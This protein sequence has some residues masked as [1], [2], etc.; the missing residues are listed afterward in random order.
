MDR[1]ER[2]ILRFNVKDNKVTAMN[3]K[4]SESIPL[5]ISLQSGG[6]SMTRIH[7]WFTVV[8]SDREYL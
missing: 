5:I 7:I 1:G 4:I 6:L 3:M 2:V 8:H